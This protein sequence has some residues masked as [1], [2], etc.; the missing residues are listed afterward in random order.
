[1]MFVVS[2]GVLMWQYLEMP[3]PLNAALIV[4]L[5]VLFWALPK[6]FIM[7]FTLNILCCQVLLMIAA[8]VAL[9]AFQM[10]FRDEL[11]GL[12]GG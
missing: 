7:P 11:T 3:R 6:T 10:A 5:L 4:G 1:A 8:A 12:P 9:E 2:F